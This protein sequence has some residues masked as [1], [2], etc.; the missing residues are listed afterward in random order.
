M[1]QLC[2]HPES[3]NEGVVQHQVAGS[4]HDFYFW[5]IIQH[6]RRPRNEKKQQVIFGSNQIIS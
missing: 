4:G 5:S 6:A 3:F 1:K 2:I